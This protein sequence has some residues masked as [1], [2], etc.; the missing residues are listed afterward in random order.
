MSSHFAGNIDNLYQPIISYELIPP[1]MTVSKE[2]KIAYAKCACQVLLNSP[3]AINAINIPEIYNEKKPGRGERPEAYLIKMDNR[4]FAN[5]L[6]NELPHHI[7][8]IINH[9]TVY[10]DWNKQKRWLKDT[11]EKYKL[12]NLIL[13]GGDS[14]SIKYPG[15]SVTD[16]AKY[17]KKEQKNFCLLGGITIPSRCYSKPLR[18]EASRLIE[19]SNA[20]INYFTSQIIYEVDGIKTLLKKY[21]VLCKQQN[22]SPNRILLSFAP[23]TNAKDLRFLTWLGVNLSEQVSQYLLSATIGMGWRSLQICKDILQE[24]LCFI[25]KEHIKVPIGLNIEHIA[26]HNFEMSC[27][28]INELGAMYVHYMKHSAH[29]KKWVTL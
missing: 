1:S 7:D 10:E 19:K 28:F 4:E 8:F 15:P 2:Q 16:F 29:R 12:Y 13:V 21:D 25:V 22:I 26:Q 5:L 17:I 20:E 24:I 23:V 6:R 3:I 14:S 18:D 11:C 9:C 27:I